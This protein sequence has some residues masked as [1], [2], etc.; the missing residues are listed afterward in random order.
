LFKIN[1]E[2]FCNFYQRKTEKEKSKRK[3]KGKK[4]GGTVP[5]HGPTTRF[6]EPVPPPSLS[7]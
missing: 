5:A 3:R 7:R 6:P 1:L 4:A 2:V